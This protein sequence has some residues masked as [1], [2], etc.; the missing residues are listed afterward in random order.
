MFILYTL[1]HVELVSAA[2]ES[3]PTFKADFNYPELSQK[4]FD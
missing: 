3:T 1:F 4:Y 2:A